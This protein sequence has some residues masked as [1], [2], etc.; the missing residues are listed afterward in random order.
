MD[1]NY[2]NKTARKSLLI[3]DVPADIR[4]ALIEDAKTQDIPVGETAIGILCAAYN[5]KHA[6]QENGLKG[7][8]TRPLRFSTA[9]AT[10]TTFVLRGG[11]ALHRKLDKARVKRDATLRGLVLEAL[12]VHYDLTPPSV[13]RRPRQEKETA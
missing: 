8:E 13:G 9:D 6:P 11:A 7:Q 5:V 12:A 3:T 2:R 10:T 1:Y 4:Q